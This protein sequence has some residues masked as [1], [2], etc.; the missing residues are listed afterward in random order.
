MLPW[1]RRVREGAQ[2]TRSVLRFVKLGFVP[3][4]PGLRTPGPSGVVESL[5]DIFPSLAPLLPSPR[6]KARG[7]GAFVAVEGHG[8]LNDSRGAEGSGA[9]PRNEGAECAMVPSSGPGRGREL[10]RE[11]GASPR[12]SLSVSDRPRSSSPVV[13]TCR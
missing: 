5:R 10:G 11:R 2:K 13:F 8:V 4:R 3:L 9:Q 1:N 12:V 7:F 6:V